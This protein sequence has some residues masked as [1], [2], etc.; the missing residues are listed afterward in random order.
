[1]LRPASGDLDMVVEVRYVPRSPVWDEIWR[2]LL[3]PLP[4]HSPTQVDGCLPHSTETSSHPGPVK[5]KSPA[6]RSVARTR[7]RVK[8]ATRAQSLP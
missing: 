2:R 5:Q 7:R 6:L 1:M 4:K 3:M 8:A